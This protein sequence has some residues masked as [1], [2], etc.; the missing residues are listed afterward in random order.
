MWSMTCGD[1]T[2]NPATLKETRGL[3]GP[4]GSS[5]KPA[6]SLESYR[7]APTWTDELSKWRKDIVT[8]EKQASEYSP[9]HSSTS[10]DTRIPGGSEIDRTYRDLSF[11]SLA[12]SLLIL[13]AEIRMWEIP[14]SKHRFDSLNFN[15]SY[16]T[17]FV[18]YDSVQSFYRQI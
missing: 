12:R 2:R 7:G 18:R 1:A 9:V 15:R 11:G 13:D 4:R 6:K 14:M 17:Q 8:Y 16:L 5:R 3:R 10:W